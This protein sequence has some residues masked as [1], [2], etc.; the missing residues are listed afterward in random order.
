MPLINNDNNSGEYYLTDIFEI[1]KN[2]NEKI[3]ISKLNKEDS[4]KCQ[5]VNDLAQLEQLEMMYKTHMNVK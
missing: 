1:M 3:G 4:W 2:N 5:G